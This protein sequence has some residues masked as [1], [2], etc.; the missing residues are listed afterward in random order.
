MPLSPALARWLS[1]RGHDAVHATAIGLER[2]PD[3]NIIEYA[4]REARIIVTADLDYPRLL[5]VA[6]AA[7]PSVI[8]FRGGEWS[9]GDIVARMARLLQNVSEP[10]FEHSILVIGPHRIRR[11]RLPIVP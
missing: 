11:R 9:D 8:L 1:E 3:S 2:A 10:D 5:A 7:E 4:R 6:A